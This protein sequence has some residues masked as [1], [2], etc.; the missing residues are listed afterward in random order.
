MS[1]YDDDSVLRK[2][3]CFFV[4]LIL[5]ALLLFVIAY[6]LNLGDKKSEA[7]SIECTVN[8]VSLVKYSN[9]STLCRY[10]YLTMPNGK[11]IEIEDKA[12]YDVAK[13]HIGQKIKIE[14]SQTYFLRKDGKKHIV[15]NH[16]FRPVK[17]LE[18]EGEYQEYEEKIQNVERKTEVPI[19]FHYFPLIR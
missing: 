11:E 15:R 10:V 12:L 5:F 6:G 17:V 7:K 8:Y 2:I 3:I 1:Y 19:Y 16:I 14:V 18:V 9:S 13:N 4:F